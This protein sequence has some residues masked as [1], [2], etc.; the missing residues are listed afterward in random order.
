MKAHLN[1]QHLEDLYRSGL[2]DETIESFGFFSGTAEEVES[3]LGFA[4][5]PGLIIPYPSHQG[6]KPFYRVKPDVPPVIDGKPAKYLSPRGATVRAYIP[7]STYDALK[8]KKTRVIVSEGEKKAAKAD[9]DGFPC[10]GLGGVYAF[11]QN[12]QLIPDLEQITWKG[13]EVIISDDSDASIKSEVKKAI[14]K[15]ER[16][17]ISRGA[18]V[19]VTRFDPAPDGSKV[20]LDDFLVSHSISDLKQVLKEAEPALFWE[21]NDISK[22]PEYQRVG[23][24]EVLFEN[25][26][27][28]EPIET[29]PWKNLCREKLGIEARIFNAQLKIAT[30]KRQVQEAATA[31]KAQKAISEQANHESTQQNAEL[32][33]KALDLL[34]HPALLYKIGSFIHRLGVAGETL[35]LL[36]VFLAITSRILEKPISIAVKGE[37]SSGKNFIV[38]HVCLM[39]PPEAYFL[40]TGMSRQALIYTSE[41]FAHRTI[42]IFEK[43]G[44]DAADLNIRTLQSE[45]RIIFETV[46]KDPLNGQFKTQRIEKEGPTNFI[47]TTTSPELHP[48]NET[49]NW[50]LTMDESSDQTRATKIQAVEKYTEGATVSEAEL[51]IW[52]RL[53]REIKPLPVRIP[54]AKWLAEHTP[55][56]PLRMRRDFPKL[57][58]LIEIIAILHQ[59]QRKNK[60][61]SIIATLEDYYLAKELIDQIFPASLSGINEKVENMVGE[62]QRIYQEQLNKGVLNPAIKPAEIARALKN[63]SSSVSRWLRPTIEAGIIEPVNTS[64]NGNRIN[65]VK[66]VDGIKLVKK[67]LPAID[68]LAEAFPEAAQDFLAVNPLTGEEVTLTADDQGIKENHEAFVKG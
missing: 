60:E 48:E 31:V 32:S 3:I 42:I 63:S 39:F 36:M 59:Y 40:L 9:Q 28:L 30:Q 56:E 50:S 27:E 66:P 15:L 62:V 14:F 57:L 26:A 29:V 54:Y 65:A 12:H 49:R 64:N 67:L 17:L 24:L 46:V 11:L 18:L 1:N 58:A 45:N 2:T 43:P 53:Q 37:S 13:R 20:G 21:I 5:G 6:I 44:M 10:I 35:N 19:R 38:E 68:T 33:V 8:N 25:L 41:D 7:P 55:D 61:G 23:P 16:E 52:K 4:A 47:T 34:R 51:A 22:L